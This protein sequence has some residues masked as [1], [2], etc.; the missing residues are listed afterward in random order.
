[1][2]FPISLWDFNCCKGLFLIP[3]KLSNLF[4]RFDASNEKITFDDILSNL[5]MRFLGWCCSLWKVQST[6]QSL[7]EILVLDVFL[8]VLVETA[9]QSL[10]EI[11]TRL[12]DY[13]VVSYFFPISLWDLRSNRW[14]R[15]GLLPF[16]SLYE[17]S[18]FQKLCYTSKPL[19]NLF[20]RFLKIIP[21]ATL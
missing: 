19:S 1:M 11:S 13:Y 15:R 3:Y 7:Y 10:Y 9:F 8:V 4:M 18:I 17:I 20:M 21:F 5:F 2:L 6:F 16:Q 12:C 14:G